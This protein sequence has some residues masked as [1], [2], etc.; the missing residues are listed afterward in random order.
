MDEADRLHAAHSVL[1][2][3]DVGPAVLPGDRHPLQCAAPVLLRHA[4]CGRER[5]IPGGSESKYLTEYLTQ[6]QK[7]GGPSPCWTPDSGEAQALLENIVEEPAFSHFQ[8]HTELDEWSR[9][10]LWGPVNTGL[11]H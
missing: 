9:V 11:L 7:T 3:A 10:G 4:L 2:P 6:T 8:V 1:R 5:D